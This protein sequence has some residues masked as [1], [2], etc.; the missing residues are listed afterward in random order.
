MTPQQLKERVEEHTGLDVSVRVR[1]KDY[2]KARQLYFW[3]NWKEGNT[4]TSAAK[5]INRDHA[6]AIHN[7]RTFQ[8][9]VD[10]RDEDTTKLV[11]TVTGKDITGTHSPIKDRAIEVATDVISSISDEEAAELIT[12]MKAFKKMTEVKHGLD[13]ITVFNGY[14][15]ISEYINKF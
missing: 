7:T 14:D 13:R 4:H 15:T 9:L 8:G 6:T 2:V 5:E 12:R 11:Y 3:L 10:I 1:T